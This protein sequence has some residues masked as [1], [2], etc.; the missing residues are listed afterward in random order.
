VIVLSP[1]TVAWTALTAALA[2]AVPGRFQVPAI[3]LSAVLFLVWADPVA[4]AVLAAQL[5]VV[6]LA[7]GRLRGRG[8]LTAAIVVLVAVPIVAFKLRAGLPHVTGLAVPLGLSFSTFRL[9]HLLVD[10]WAG[11]LG[12]RR[13]GDVLAYV[14]LLPAIP[15]G[16][17]HRFPDFLV[18]LRRRRFDAALVGTGL[19]RIL[20]GYAKL[21]VLRNV[22]VVPVLLPLLTGRAGESFGGDLLA[23][24]GEWID[25]YLSFSGCS[26]LAIGWSLVMGFRLIENFDHPYLASSIPDFWRRWH[27]SLTSWARDYV[28]APLAAA[29]R[30]PVVG[31]AAAM[32]TI[33]LWHEL[34][35]R[36]VLWGLYHAVGILLW[37][38]LA[39]RLPAPSGRLALVLRPLGTLATLV[40]VLSSFAVTSRL[41]GA[42]HTL[43][44]LVF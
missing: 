35:S 39:A 40:F 36:Y 24:A 13:P 19:E 26:D 28:F 33:G 44:G 31:V 1:A 34:S 16:P 29:T 42:L 9:V 12:S 22:F 8:A 27:I 7:L 25:I 21:V 11:R 38:A 17:I 23:S 41:D 4:L 30:R 10:A 3:V 37:H 2:W 32:L 15:S 14:L 43:L 20:H 5:A 18:D 6:L